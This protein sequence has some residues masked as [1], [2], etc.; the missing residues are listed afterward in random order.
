MTYHMSKRFDTPIL[1]SCWYNIYAKKLNC[2]LGVTGRVGS[3][4]S[5][6]AVKVAS[7]FDPRFDIEENLVYSVEAL[8]KT[9][10]SF[11]KYKGEPLSRE[12]FEKIPSL[13]TWLKANV[14]Y[15]RIKPGRALVFDEAGSAAYVREFFSQD[16]KSLAKVLQIWRFLRLLVIIVVPEDLKLADSTVTKFLNMEIKM[17]GVNHEKNEA[18]C[19]AWTYTGWNKKTKEHIKKRV[20]GCRFGGTIFVTPLPDDTAKRYEEISRVHKIHALLEM[21]MAYVLDKKQDIG[22]TRSL[23]DDV[24]YVKGHLGEFKNAKGDITI[25]KIQARLGISNPKARLVREHLGDIH[26][27]TKPRTVEI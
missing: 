9:S 2:L 1:R 10:L 14:K 12:M 8:L 6:L 3:G 13:V 4:K 27:E 17:L 19:I 23:W 7:S 5:H 20:K 22:K 25:S 11:I 16:N 26:D 18:S 24:Q 15:I 21:Q